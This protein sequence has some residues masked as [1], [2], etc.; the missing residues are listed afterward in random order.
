MSNSES[1]IHEYQGNQFRLEKKR[2]SNNSAWKISG[3]VT[4]KE[5]LI[6]PSDYKGNPICGWKM[7]SKE[8]PLHAVRFLSIPD[9]I[10]EISIQS[11]PFPNWS[12][13]KYKLAIRSFPRMDRCFFQLMETSRIAKRPF[14]GKSQK[15][16]FCGWCDFYKR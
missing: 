2:Y 10:T 16:L 4:A 1:L 14:A 7:N 6:L 11:R 3:I 13:C 9:S 8:K 15:I 5:N 12:R